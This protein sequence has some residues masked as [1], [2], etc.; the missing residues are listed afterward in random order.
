VADLW[1]LPIITALVL[2]ASRVI[3]VPQSFGGGDD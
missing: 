2:V 3:S 1:A